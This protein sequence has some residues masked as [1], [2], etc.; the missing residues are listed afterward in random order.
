MTK[1]TWIPK[2]GDCV[3]VVSL[4]PVEATKKRVNLRLVADLRLGDEGFITSGL[5]D[6]NG[7]FDVYFNRILQ[8]VCCNREMVAPYDK[9]CMDLKGVG[10]RGFIYDHRGGAEWFER[11][12]DSEHEI[13]SHL[14]DRMGWRSNSYIDAEHEFPV[15][16]IW[17]DEDE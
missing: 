12:Y 8:T 6:A 10:S 1:D 13:L 9:V 16:E 14:A 2:P 5:V 4:A 7:V 15:T 3:E 17:R 11:W